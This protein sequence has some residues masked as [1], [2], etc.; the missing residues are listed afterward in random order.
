MKNQDSFKFKKVKF[1]AILWILLN[2]EVKSYFNV[3]SKKRTLLLGSLSL[4]NWALGLGFLLETLASF[5]TMGDSRLC[6]GPYT[7]CSTWN[8]LPVL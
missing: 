6:L 4:E 1:L 3:T 5:R 7:S 8:D 2:V